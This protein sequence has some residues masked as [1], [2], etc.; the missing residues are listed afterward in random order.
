MVRTMANSPVLKEIWALGAQWCHKTSNLSFSQREKL[1]L[2]V[3]RNEL[4]F[5]SSQARVLAGKGVSL[6]FSPHLCVGFLFLILY[7]ASASAASSLHTQLCHTPSFSHHLT[8]TTLSDSIFHTLRVAG[9]ALGDIHLRFAWQAW[10]LVTSTFTLCGRRGTNGTKRLSL[11]HLQP[12]FLHCRQVPA[13]ASWRKD[14]VHVRC[15]GSD[16]GRFTF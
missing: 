5:D 16:A 3:L 13:R 10:H 6:Y 11:Y 8:H 2:D 1:K 7:P 9:V 14:H 12:C 15:S 4:G